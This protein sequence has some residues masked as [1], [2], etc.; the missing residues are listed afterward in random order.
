MRDGWPLLGSESVVELHA[1]IITTI[2][3]PMQFSL[4]SDIPASAKLRPT[5]VAIVT[6]GY[7]A[8]NLVGCSLPEDGLERG[9]N[10]GKH[11]CANL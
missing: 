1:A 9:N 11:L 8:F 7:E 4:L 2:S 10:G 5:L 6:R 3:H